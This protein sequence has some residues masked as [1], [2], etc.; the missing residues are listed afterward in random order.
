MG[1]TLCEFCRFA[2]DAKL[3]VNPSALAKD[4]CTNKGSV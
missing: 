4:F 3:E 1:N 2:G